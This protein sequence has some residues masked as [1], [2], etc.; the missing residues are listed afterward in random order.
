MNGEKQKGSENDLN[1]TSNIRHPKS[2]GFHLTAGAGTVSI[3]N[4][5]AL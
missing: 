5:K 1:P 4:A 2:I 3:A